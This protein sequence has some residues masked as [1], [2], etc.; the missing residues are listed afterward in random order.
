MSCL[1]RERKLNTNFLFSQTFRAPPGCPAKNPAISRQKSL[2]SLGFEGQTELLGPHPFAWK[3]PTPTGG[4]PDPKVWVWVPFSCLINVFCFLAVPILVSGSKN[5]GTTPLINLGPA[6]AEMCQG[7]LLY[8]LW[9]ILPGIFLEDFS[10]HFFPHKKREKHSAT[11]S[12]NKS[13][14]SKI[15]I[16]ENSA[17]PKTD[18]NKSGTPCKFRAFIGHMVL[19]ECMQQLRNGVVKELLELQNCELHCILIRCAS[20]GQEAL[21]HLHTVGCSEKGWIPQGVSLQ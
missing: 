4:Y 5:S 3:T 6:P 11:K 19:W 2:V 8:K 10:G 1:F 17:L 21:Q 15:R 20:V 13:G 16:R 7:F 18:P 14:G 9:R 12:A